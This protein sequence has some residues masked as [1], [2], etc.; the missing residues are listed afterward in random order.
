M[1]KENTIIEEVPGILPAW[2]FNGPGIETG[3]YPCFATLE[4]AKEWCEQ[5]GRVPYVVE[6]FKP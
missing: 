2:F 1:R 4:K 6:Y 5:N 3:Q